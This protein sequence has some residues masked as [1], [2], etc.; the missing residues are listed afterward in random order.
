MALTRFPSGKP[1]DSTALEAA[2]LRQKSNQQ[3]EALRE[4]EKEHCEL[5]VTVLRA[6]GASLGDVPVKYRGRVQSLMGG[7]HE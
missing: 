2:A 6:G 5:W 3:E 1:H 4:L 7:A